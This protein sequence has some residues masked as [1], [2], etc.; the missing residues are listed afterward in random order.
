M[1]FDLYSSSEMCEKNCP[2]RGKGTEQRTPIPF[3]ILHLMQKESI[4][5]TGID[6]FLHLYIRCLVKTHVE[7]IAGNYINIHGDKRRASMDIESLGRQAFIHWNG[8]P[9]HFAD[10]RGRRVSIDISITILGTSS[11]S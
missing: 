11:P 2:K 7:G 10:N 8:P 6:E 9:L 3:R 1:L 4:L 5:N